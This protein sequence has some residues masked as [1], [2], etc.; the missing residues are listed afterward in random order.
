MHK[1]ILLSVLE[2]KNGARILRIVLKE[3][4]GDGDKIKFYRCSKIYPNI[5]FF[6]VLSLKNEKKK[7]SNVYLTAASRRLD[8]YAC[9]ISIGTIH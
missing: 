4:V 1:S 9:S 3:I 8:V 5:N 6:I 2:K 7:K